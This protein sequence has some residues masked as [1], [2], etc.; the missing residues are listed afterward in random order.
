M[1]IFRW[2]RVLPVPPQLLQ[3]LWMIFPVPLHLGQVAVVVKLKG[4]PLRWMRT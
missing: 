2:R 4:P 3:G 1:V